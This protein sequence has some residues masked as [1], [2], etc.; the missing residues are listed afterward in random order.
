[1]STTP[2]IFYNAKDLHQVNDLLRS[3]V[4][5]LLQER[6]QYP[7]VVN[8]AVDV[9]A[10]PEHNA[11]K[12]RLDCTSGARNYTVS[13]DLPVGWTVEVSKT[14]ASANT[15]TFTGTGVNFNVLGS[16]TVASY[17][18]TSQFNYWRLRHVGS[19]VFDIT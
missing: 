7:V 3:I 17:S 10:T 16:G 6:S 4:T 2:P 14:D 11:G 5:Y 8:S 12:V 19:G 18:F 13:A 15:V 1:M 9:D